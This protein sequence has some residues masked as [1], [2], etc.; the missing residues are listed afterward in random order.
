MAASSLR[1]FFVSMCMCNCKASTAGET[2][3]AKCISCGVLPHLTLN[4]GGPLTDT[5]RYILVGSPIVNLLGS[6]AIIL[7]RYS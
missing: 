4:K 2:N 3:S 6:L 5:F 7:A 1:K